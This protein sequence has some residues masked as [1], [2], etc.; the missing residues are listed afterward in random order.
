MNIHDIIDAMQGTIEGQR[1][2][3]EMALGEVRRL[4]D[5]VKG[6]RRTLWLV[7]DRYAAGTADFDERDVITLPDSAEL[8]SWR[9]GGT[10]KMYIRAREGKS[11]K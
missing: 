2:G 9:D 7:I 11:Q 10:G 8:S 5:E 4:R 6:L 3:I 1:D